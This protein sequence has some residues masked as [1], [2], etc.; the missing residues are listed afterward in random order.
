MS[1]GRI[2]A[3]PQLATRNFGSQTVINQHCE[4]N[5]E[6]STATKAILICI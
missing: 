5:K 3:S 2:C 6:T 1:R 4:L